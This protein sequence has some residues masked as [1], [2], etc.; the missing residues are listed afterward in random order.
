MSHNTPQT[1]HDTLAAYR[2]YADPLGAVLDATSDWDAMSPCGG[3][4]AADLVAHVIE[5]ERD[6]FSRHAIDLGPA[7]AVAANPAS[8]WHTHHA[9]VQ[10]VLADE[11]VAARAFDG[12]FGPTTVGAMFLQVYG[13]D[14]VVHRWDLAS[15]A[16]R[17]ERF[18]E[19]E[20]DT[21]EAAIAG[22]GDNLYADGICAPAIDVPADADRQSR[23]LAALGRRG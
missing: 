10:R 12:F 23:V 17:D 20:L 4:T 7:P 6:Y 3:W 8:A 18:T 9:A 14:L 5:T 11:A 15:A 22:F 2:Q 1:G 21:V 19:T 16:S 13:F